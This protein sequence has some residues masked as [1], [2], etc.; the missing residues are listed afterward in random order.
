MTSATGW[1]DQMRTAGW[2]VCDA[3]G[4]H[5]ETPSAIHVMCFGAMLGSGTVLEVTPTTARIL[6][7]GGA[8][9]TFYRRDYRWAVPIWEVS[10][11]SKTIPAN[12]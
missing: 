4:V 2:T 8:N 7:P 5:P 11:S 9:Q 1:V 6:T 10:A 3:L 12:S